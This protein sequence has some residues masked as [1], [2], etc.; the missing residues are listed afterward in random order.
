MIVEN[1]SRMARGRSGPV[2]KISIVTP[3]FNQRLFVA[4]AL[5]SVKA[6]V[7]EAELEHIVVDGGSSDG[8]VELLRQ[9]S[10]QPGWSHLH[11]ASESDK[12]QSDAL[13]KGFRRAT[14][15]VVG[16]L[17]ADDRYL[18]DAIEIVRRE[19]DRNCNTDVLYGDYRWIDANGRVTQV[20]RTPAFSRF[21]LYYHRV[22]VIPTT[23]CFFR[24][25]IFDDGVFLSERHHLAMDVEFFLRLEQLGYRFQH[26]GEILAEYRWHRANKSSLHAVKQAEEANRAIIEATALREI[27]NPVAQ[28]FVLSVLRAAAAARH[29]SAKAFHGYYFEQFW[30]LVQ[31]RGKTE[32]EESVKNSTRGGS[33]I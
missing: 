8:T 25:C 2:K 13:N 31:N 4:D 3:S 27:K 18:P 33:G 17:N 9:L 16:W 22:L 12:G 10:E 29:W 28:R 32:A 15:D 5:E 26:V 14:G 24:R 30:P 19:L 21:V 1:C 20:R 11:W 23:A 7:C 6:Q